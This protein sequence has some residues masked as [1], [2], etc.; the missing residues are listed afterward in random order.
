MKKRQKYGTQDILTRILFPII[1]NPHLSRLLKRWVNSTNANN[2]TDPQSPPP[3]KA[4]V[5]TGSFL[6]YSSPFTFPFLTMFT[7]DAPSLPKGRV[8]RGQYSLDGNGSMIKDTQVGV[9]QV[10]ISYILGEIIRPS[11]GKGQTCHYIGYVDFF[12]AEPPADQDSLIL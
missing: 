4:I 2:F 8:P 7:S 6:N 10:Q 1:S 5:T 9:Q 11:Q 3:L 12:I